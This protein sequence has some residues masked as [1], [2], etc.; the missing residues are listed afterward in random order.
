M[1]EKEYKEEIVRLDIYLMDSDENPNY[2]YLREEI[3]RLEGNLDDANTI[4][5]NLP[6]ELGYNLTISKLD[7][8]GFRT[9]IGHRGFF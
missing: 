3:A 7:W 1:T 9:C 8:L 5:K 6:S 4:I 2:Q